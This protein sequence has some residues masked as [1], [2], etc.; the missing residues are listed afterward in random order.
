MGKLN[1]KGLCKQIKDSRNNLIW[2]FDGK[3]H[4]ITN[5]H[6][7][8]KLEHIVTDVL[9]SLLTVFDGQSPD[10]GTSLKKHVFFSEIEKGVLISSPPLNEGR[11]SLSWTN[12]YRDYT[13]PR[14]LLRVFSLDNSSVYINTN[15]LHVCGSSQLK[16]E[17][18]NALRV[19]FFPEI[20]YMVLPVR[21]TNEIDILALVDA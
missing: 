12:F 18:T 19:I 7:I 11:K 10:A 1:V 4:L 8:I 2:S 15:Y 21:I 20:N 3:E 9:I 16:V 17:G 5:R 6:W 14:E 13:G